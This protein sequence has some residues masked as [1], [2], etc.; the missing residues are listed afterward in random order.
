VDANGLEVQGPLE[1]IQPSATKVQDISLGGFGSDVVWR[2]NG[3]IAV[4]ETSSLGHLVDTRLLTVRP[5]GAVRRAAAIG[6]IAAAAWTSNGGA[7]AV[8]RCGPARSHPS[9]DVLSSSGRL[10]RH[11]GP[12]PGA[13]SAGACEDPLAG[14]D[15]DLA[16]TPDGRSLFV[17]L[18]TGLWALSL[19]G[20]SPRRI[21]Q[22]FLP[23]T[24]PAVSPDGRQI[25]IEGSG[26]RAGNSGGLLYVM[27]AAGGPTRQITTN[28]ASQPAWSPDGRLIAFVS[29]PGDAISM[30]PRNG[31][32]VTTLARLSGTQISSLSWSPSGRQLAFTA[33]GRPPED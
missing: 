15:E 21:E 14:A 28:P 29:G 20:A 32:A 31:G 17:D 9:I 33:S 4:L 6:P 22:S 23:L 5:S 11:L 12:L 1:V 24:A 26:A 2:S 30:I 18:S 8:A 7:L 16:W 27:P 25:V 3:S 19:D 10:R 13:L